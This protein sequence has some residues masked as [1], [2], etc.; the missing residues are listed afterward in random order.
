MIDRGG[1]VEGVSMSFVRAI[2]S[3]AKITPASPAAET[4]TA[5]EDKGEGEER[6]SR[7]PVYD[8]GPDGEVVND[9][10]GSGNARTAVKKDRTKDVM[11][12]S[13]IECT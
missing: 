11:V 8:D 3:G 13:M 10:P 1:W 9:R 6:M 5:R 2:S 12:E 4:A 7:P